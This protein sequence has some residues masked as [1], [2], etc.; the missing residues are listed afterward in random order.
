MASNIANLGNGVSSFIIPPV[1]ASEVVVSVSQTEYE[2]SA[3]EK[4]GKEKMTAEEYV[5]N[6]FSDIPIMVEIAKCESRFRHNNS[7]GIA[8][9]GEKNNLD[10]GVMQIN[11]YFHNEDSNKLGYD[12]LTIEGNTSYARRLFE[13]YGI[14]PWRSSFKCWSRTIAYSEYELAKELAMKW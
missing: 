8:L 1:A 5:R 6:Y 7:N 14:K 9:R 2:E 13:K 3:D 10:R 12:I 11:E 4:A